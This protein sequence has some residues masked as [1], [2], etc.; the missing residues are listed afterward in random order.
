MSLDN[1]SPN[2]EI[3]GRNI[4]HSLM[5][6]NLLVF[7]LIMVIVIYGLGFNFKLNTLILETA[8]STAAVALVETDLS[9]QEEDMSA[10]GKWFKMRF[11]S[12]TM[13]ER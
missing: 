8:A 10:A 1:S 9:K 11:D 13:C 5:Y 3:I 6:L 4:S 7:L 2:L 12:P